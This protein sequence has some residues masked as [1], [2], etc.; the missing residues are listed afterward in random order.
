M[1]R[2]EFIARQSGRPTGWIGRGLARIMAVETAAANQAA[3]ELLHLGD[4][5]RVLDV[6]YGHGRTIARAT[7]LVPRGFVAGIDHSDAMLRSARRR[8]AALIA[9]GRVQ[10]HCGDS[11]HLPFGDAAFDK[12][13]AVHTLYFWRPPQP[14]LRE[15]HRVL[16]PGGRLVLAYRPAGTRG[17]G[18]F[19]D[20][21]YTFH[22]ADDVHELLVAA[23]FGA[24]ETVRPSP[25]LALTA[26]HAN[27]RRDPG[28]HAPQEVTP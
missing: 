4:A 22:S 3:L 7:E 17:V 25:D 20:D 21:I 18:D 26:A 11:A 1:R 23:G 28:D 2:P 13:L 12:A 9:S 8:C 5:D 16:V 6:G 27:G 10:L 14:H 24:V 15:I 19:P